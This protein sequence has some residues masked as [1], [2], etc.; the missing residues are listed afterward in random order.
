MTK[1]RFVTLT[2]EGW[3]QFE[4]E[5][6]D[7][8]AL[9]NAMAEKGIRQRGWNMSRHVREELRA[10]PTFEGFA[11]PMWDGDAIRY[12]DFRANDALSA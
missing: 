12:E 8:T 11:G 7:G 1:A 2:A 6:E 4:V 10:K 5:A 9:I 3:G